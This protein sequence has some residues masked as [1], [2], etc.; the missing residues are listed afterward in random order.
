M[1][2]EI[3][4]S[5]FVDFDFPG[6]NGFMVE[7]E[8]GL[9]PKGWEVGKLED[10]AVVTSWKRPNSKSDKL[11]WDFQIPILWA[12]GVMWYTTDILFD[13][14]LIVMGRVWTHWQISRVNYPCRPSDNTL[15]TQSNYFEY[16]YQ[17][18]CWI[19]FSSLNKWAVQPLITQTDIRNYKLI[20]PSDDT[21]REFEKHNWEMFEKV[22]LN[23]SE[24]ENLVKARDS[25]LPKIMSG[26]VRVF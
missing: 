10:I 26:K 20:L 21:L 19:D 16:V 8:M 9:I 5:W 13:K 14:H 4:K 17:T 12:G 1:G 7:S 23:N 15:I 11:E 6:S 18:I 3:F 2:Q 22:Y 24:I 25:L